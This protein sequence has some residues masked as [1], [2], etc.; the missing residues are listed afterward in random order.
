MT[1][2]HIDPQWIG[3]E[4][5]LWLAHQGALAV[6]GILEGHGDMGVRVRYQRQINIRS[7]T[8][9]GQT[10][11]DEGTS[12]SKPQSDIASCDGIDRIELI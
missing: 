10:W 6:R 3:Q 9:E 1:R 5:M 11:T 12:L 8:D 7:S 2:V 4:V